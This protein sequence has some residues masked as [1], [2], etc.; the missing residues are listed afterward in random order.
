M[1]ASHPFSPSVFYSRA[2]SFLPIV[3]LPVMKPAAYLRLEKIGLCT[4]ATWP[5][6]VTPH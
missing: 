6:P 3:P 4:E 1:T 5:A 2:H